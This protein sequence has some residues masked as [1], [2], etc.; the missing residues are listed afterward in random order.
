MALFRRDFKMATLP[1]VKMIHAHSCY[2]GISIHNSRPFLLTGAMALAPV[3]KFQDTTC[4]V[5]SNV[6]P[7][8]TIFGFYCLLSFYICRKLFDTEVHTAADRAAVLAL[9]EQA[10]ELRNE[11]SRATR[12]KDALYAKYRKIKVF[13]EL[14]VR[15]EIYSSMTHWISQCL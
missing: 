15:T 7:R 3:S 6:F 10:E 2:T 4:P 9:D 1:K 14:A 12:E 5:H 13:K 11:I 8:L